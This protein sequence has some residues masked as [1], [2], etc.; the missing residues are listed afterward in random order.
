MH[1]KDSFVYLGWG[2][3]RRS[4]ALGEALNHPQK[5]GIGTNPTIVWVGSLVAVL[6]HEF[7]AEQLRDRKMDAVEAKS[8]FLEEAG[9][10]EYSVNQFLNIV[11]NE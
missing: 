6:Y 2:D 4:I 1:V 9:I 7:M 11:N 8:F 5:G 3:S 10:P